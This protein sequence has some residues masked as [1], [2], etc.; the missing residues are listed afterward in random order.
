M[1]PLTIFTVI[2]ICAT[3]LG[4]GFGLLALLLPADDAFETDSLEIWFAALGAGILINSWFIFTLT[5]FGLF[6]VTGLALFSLILAILGGWR[7]K[8]TRSFKKV[9]WKN[10]THWALS[11]GMH[12]PVWVEVVLLSGWL[13]IATVLFFRPHQHIWGGADVGVYINY[14]SHIAQTGQ[15]GL[16]EPLL[17]DIPAEILPK[18]LGAQN[19]GS[20]W[21]YIT[22]ALDVNDQSGQIYF[23]FYHLQPIWQAVGWG[24]NGLDAALMLTPLWGLIATL[25]FYFL[26]RHMLHKRAW[27]W[28]FVALIAMT[29]NPL[30][31]WFTRYGTTEALTQLLFTLGFIAFCGWHQTEYKSWLWGGIAGAAF[32]MTFLARI[33]TFFIGLIPALMIALFLL[34]RL[35]WQDLMVFLTPFLLLAIH[36]TIHGAAFSPEYTTRLGYRIFVVF[37]DVGSWFISAGILAGLMFAFGVWFFKDWVTHHLPKLRWVAVF[38]IIAYALY[39]WFIRPTTGDSFTFLL[40]GVEATSINHENLPRMG[41]YFMPFGVWLSI[42]GMVYIFQQRKWTFWYVLLP[43][44]FYWFFYTWNLQ[45]NGQHIYVMRRYVPIVLP[46]MMIASTMLL[47]AIAA[48]RV[49]HVRWAAW[50]LTAVWIGGL[51]SGSN[52]LVTHVDYNGTPE[53]LTRFS[54]Q[55]DPNSI[56]IFNQSAPVDIGDFAALPL[57]LMH[58]HSAFILHNPDADDV[59][60]LA[61][62]MDLWIQNGKTVYWA[63]LYT[64]DSALIDQKFDISASYPLILTGDLLLSSYDTRPE[65]IAEFNWQY[66]FHKLSNQT[67]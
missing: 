45:S 5:E 50:I 62:T 13:I 26:M 47:S 65:T 7:V 40:N 66:V 60:I 21:S 14:A 2:L 22:P 24:M 48:N 19:P 63:D 52:G 55:L 41:W 67:N 29:F 38:A 33:D 15:L 16:N 11:A 25:G 20:E 44:L 43:G 35:R 6:S 61:P 3:C 9:F 18:F 58:G 57:R 46:F 12:L 51:L 17:A 23:S 27:L 31:L 28:G 32:G 37:I 8:T 36:G 30:Q 4:S 10:Q 34:R 59:D 53:Q 42:I 64:T 39:S 54:D 49:K 1:Q 56:I